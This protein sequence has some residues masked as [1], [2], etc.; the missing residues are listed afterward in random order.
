LE[1]VTTASIC[2][3]ATTPE[4]LA[5]SADLGKDDITVIGGGGLLDHSDR[6]NFA[7]KYYCQITTCRFT[8]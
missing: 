6:W 5:A 7:M 2:V 1:N 4:V 3:D 8:T